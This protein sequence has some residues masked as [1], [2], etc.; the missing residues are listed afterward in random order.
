MS[1]NNRGFSSP[2][3]ER[4]PPLETKQTSLTLSHPDYTDVSWV[5][6][7]VSIYYM[8]RHVNT[9]CSWTPLQKETSWKRLPR[10]CPTYSDPTVS[11]P[12]T[13]YTHSYARNPRL[14][15]ILA[16]SARR[17]GNHIE[18]SSP[19]S[20]TRQM[21]TLPPPSH[22]EEP[23]SLSH[24]PQGPTASCPNPRHPVMITRLPRHA[25]EGQATPN[26]RKSCARAT[27][28]LPGTVRL[29]T[30]TS[31]EPRHRQEW[32]CL[33]FLTTSKVL[34]PPQWKKTSYIVIPLTTGKW[35]PW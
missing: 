6:T 32:N 14:V 3:L 17:L 12:S 22:P 21:T 18:R 27:E 30:K 33:P 13:S 5:P 26:Y 11:T 34:L 7:A 28:F 15:N 16:D 1:Q 9:Y 24:S 35:P 20:S 25:L 2:D 8:W 31:L 29:Y 4:L 10:L 23:P 19:V